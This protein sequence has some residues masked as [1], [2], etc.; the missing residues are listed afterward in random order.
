MGRVP[1]M[2]ERLQDTMQ[3]CTPAHAADWSAVD[4][5]NGDLL[6]VGSSMHLWNRLN[7]SNHI[8]WSIYVHEAQESPLI[9]LALWVL[10]NDGSLTAIEAGMTT[11]CAPLWSNNRSSGTWAWRDPDYVVSPRRLDPDHARRHLIG[12]SELGVY[13]WVCLPKA[14]ELR[15]VMVDQAAS[16]ISRCVSTPD[17]WRCPTPT[18]HFSCYYTR[19]VEP[20][21]ETICPRCGLTREEADHRSEEHTRQ[22]LQAF[23]RR[24]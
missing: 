1:T 12:P 5:K 24:R 9:R 18:L 19:L 23:E 16:R 11:L 17:L 21:A 3:W 6:Y 7:P 15:R 8:M 10:P 22:A 2:E 13:A 14:A 20:T 4:R